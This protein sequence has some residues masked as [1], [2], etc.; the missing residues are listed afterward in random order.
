M[1]ENLKII[2]VVCAICVIV[3]ALCIKKIGREQTLSWAMKVLSPIC[4]ILFYLSGVSIIVPILGKLQ[5]ANDTVLSNES[6]RVAIDSAIV[7]LFINVVLSFLNSPIKVEVEARSR[8]DIEQV[9]IS[10]NRSS[11]IEYSVKIISK[12]KWLLRRCKKYEAPVL[13][14]NNSK[15]TSIAVDKEE[16]YGDIIDASNASKHIDIHLSQFPESGKI[17][18]TLAIQSNKTIKWDD[19]ITTDFY[20]RKSMKAS[21]NALFWYVNRSS[22]KIAHREESL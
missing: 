22:I 21:G 18:F 9:L 1:K 7:T 16:E 5:V 6:I 3:S 14:I 12:Y 11:K 8:Q 17:Y 20:I 10:C 13:R 15:N 2:F 19:A 4:I